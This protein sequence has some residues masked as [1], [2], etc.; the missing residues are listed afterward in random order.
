MT[1]LDVAFAFALQVGLILPR[2]DRRR[3]H[4]IAFRYLNGH[5]LDLDLGAEVD[6]A[7][8][9]LVSAQVIVD[10]VAFERVWF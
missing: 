1:R 3:P 5:V 8:D 4:P 10:G 2:K 6:H 7:V 9:A